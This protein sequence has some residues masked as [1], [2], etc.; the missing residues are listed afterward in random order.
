MSAR[1]RIFKKL[2]RDIRRQKPVLIKQIAKELLTAPLR[3][4][5]KVAWKIVKG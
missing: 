5:I 3:E 1:T 4:R 2:H